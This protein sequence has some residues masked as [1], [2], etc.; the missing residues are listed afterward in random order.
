MVAREERSD[1]E[2]AARRAKYFVG[3]LWHLG[4][5]IILNAFLWAL[6]L[7]LGQSGL[8]WAHWITATWALGLI[9]HVL[10]W[11]IDGRQV[12]RRRTERYLEKEHSAH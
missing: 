4:A 11:L 5:F 1:K 9:F 6:D 3:L 7:F 12:E 2:L 10:A 8:Q